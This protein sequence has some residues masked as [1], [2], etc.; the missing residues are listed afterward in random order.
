MAEPN[1]SLFC[2]RVRPCCSIQTSLEQV[3]ARLRD[4][5][6]PADVKETDGWNP[7]AILYEKLT[8]VHFR[9]P[10]VLPERDAA[11]PA[12]NSSLARGRR[13]ASLPPRSCLLYTS[14]SPRDS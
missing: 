3:R 14:P 1:A 6:T 11:R 12:R 10:D 8:F 4:V 9:I 5:K 7:D 2:G 13:W